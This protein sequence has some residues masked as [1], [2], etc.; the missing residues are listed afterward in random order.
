M[1]WWLR[2]IGCSGSD[3]VL[4]NDD[5]KYPRLAGYWDG[6]VSAD[7]GDSWLGAEMD[8]LVGLYGT[9]RCCCGQRCWEGEPD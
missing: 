9:G 7:G 3:D 8:N 2:V 1:S 6:A 4:Q 5:S